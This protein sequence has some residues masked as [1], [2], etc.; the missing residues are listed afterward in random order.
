MRTGVGGAPSD[1]HFQSTGG[2]EAGLIEKEVASFG[3]GGVLYCSTGLCL[4][5]QTGDLMAFSKS[6]PFGLKS[7]GRSDCRSSGS[8]LLSMLD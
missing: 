3:E 5:R 2:T 7:H 8:V 4:E 6:A 1:V